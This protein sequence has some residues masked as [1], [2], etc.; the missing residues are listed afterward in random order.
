MLDRVY[1]GAVPGGRDLREHMRVI[2]GHGGE[3]DSLVS[4][5]QRLEAR[6]TLAQHGEIID[7]ERLFGTHG[8]SQ[9]L[10]R[11]GHD[12]FTSLSS[13]RPSSARIISSPGW[14][15]A[16]ARPAEPIKA[17]RAALQPSSAAARIRG[18][19]EPRH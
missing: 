6:K 19:G 16:A 13:L 12:D 15:G 8:V 4:N 18:C 2:V 1:E 11:N 14:R 10:G 5:R 7:V 9:N 17:A 3:M